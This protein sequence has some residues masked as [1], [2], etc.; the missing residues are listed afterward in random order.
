MSRL[1]E[2]SWRLHVSRYPL[3]FDMRA[4]FSDMDSFGHLNN[5]ALARMLEEGR[6]NLQIELIGAHHLVHPGA[7]LQLLMAN[8]EIDYVSQ[9]EYPGDV[10]VAT[11]ITQIG[12]SSIREAGGLFQGER[13]IALGDAVMVHTVGGRP[14]ALA[15]ALR[16]RL[17]R[18]RAD[19]G[20]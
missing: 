15:D 10:T 5:V 20:P 11:A 3:V 18:Y 12:R 1:R 8:I 2:E 19:M 14:A 4:A 6:A 7:G 13:C 9:G 16:A 17:D